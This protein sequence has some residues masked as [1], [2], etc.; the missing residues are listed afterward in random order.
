MNNTIKT[1]IETLQDLKLEDIIVYDMR[2]RS[3]FFDFCVLSTARS[4]RQLQAALKHLKDNL[5]AAKHK[6]PMI[7]GAGSDGWVLMDAK[8]V[9]VNI[10]TREERTYYNL[11][12]MWMDIPT[13]DIEA[14]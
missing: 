4:S 11:E 6:M 14:C 10:F 2:E 3:P 9:I 12:K 5:Q 13:V 8:D 1:V 7:E